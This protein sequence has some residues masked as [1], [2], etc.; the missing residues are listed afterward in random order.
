M[1][2]NLCIYMNYGGGDH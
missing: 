1:S 2:S